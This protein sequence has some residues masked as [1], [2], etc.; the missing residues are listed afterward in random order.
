MDQMKDL[1]VKDLRLLL[2]YNLRSETFKGSPK[3]V[4]LVE[5]VTEF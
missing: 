4:E 3:K 1:K 5:A 2:C